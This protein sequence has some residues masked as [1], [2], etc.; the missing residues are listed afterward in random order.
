MGSDLTPD[1]IAELDRLEKLDASY[2]WYVHNEM[3]SHVLGTEH[4]YVV[5]KADSIP[6]MDGR[7]LSQ[8]SHDRALFIAALRNSARPLLDLVESQQKEIAELK[9][10]LYSK[11][12][13]K[14]EGDKECWNAALDVISNQKEEIARLRQ[15]V[16]EAGEEPHPPQAEAKCSKHDNLYVARC[17]KCE[18]EEASQ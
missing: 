17:L 8:R 2:P 4:G 3:P 11:P 14:T 13:N 5:A 10:I 18:A 16:G 9:A 6:S 1:R 7:S 15:M 12:H